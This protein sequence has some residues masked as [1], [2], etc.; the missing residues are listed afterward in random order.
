VIGL[1]G[2]LRSGWSSFLW[3]EEM[4]VL[5]QKNARSNQNP[6]RISLDLMRSHQ[7]GEDLTRSNEISPYLMRSC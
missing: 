2:R 3:L 5:W 4:V 6:A 7:I 1:V